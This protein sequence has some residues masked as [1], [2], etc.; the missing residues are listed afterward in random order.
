MVYTC[1]ILQAM[2]FSDTYTQYEKEFFT[3]E[4]IALKQQPLTLSDKIKINS[5]S[6]LSSRIESK[7]Q[8]NEANKNL[9]HR[10]IIYDPPDQ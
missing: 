2:L 8:Q 3:R 4:R 5:F 10:I 9:L 6:I 1:K 7:S